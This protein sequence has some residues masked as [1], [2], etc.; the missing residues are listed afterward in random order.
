MR[1][2]HACYYLSYEWS[3][4]FFYDT[5]DKGFSKKIELVNFCFKEAIWHFYIPLRCFMYIDVCAGFKK[6]QTEAFWM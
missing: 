5:D 3:R 4:M 2:I 1:D 6:S